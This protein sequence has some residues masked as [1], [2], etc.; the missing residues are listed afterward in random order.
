MPGKALIRANNVFWGTRQ[1][2]SIQ[3]GKRACTGRFFAFNAVVIFFFAQRHKEHQ[4]ESTFYA[5]IDLSLTS[6]LTKIPK[7][8]RRFLFLFLS[9]QRFTLLT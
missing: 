5:V 8:R 9:H 2:F 1:W 3:K 6:N 4:P 7:D